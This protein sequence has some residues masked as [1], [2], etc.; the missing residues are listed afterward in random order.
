VPA[1]LVIA[2]LTFIG[3]SVAG[4]VFGFAPEGAAEGMAATSPWI[5]ALVAAIAVL[6]VACPC[7]LGL[8]TPTAIM[9]GTGQGAERGIL[10]RNG[11]SLER[12]GAVRTLALDKTGTITSGKPTL[13]QVVLPP[14]AALSEREALQL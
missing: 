10:I 13:T 7:A 5:V 14:G 1:V 4:Y 12:F 11:E 8:A 6:V 2:L 9:V 3:W